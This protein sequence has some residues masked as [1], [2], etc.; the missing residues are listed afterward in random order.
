MNAAIVAAAYAAMRGGVDVPRLQ[1]GWCLRTVRRILEHAL[2][3]PEEELFRRFPAQVE[4][5]KPKPRAYWAR[6]VQASFRAAGFGVPATETLPGDVVAYWR[7]AQNDEGDYVGHIGVRLPGGFVLENIDAKYRL[8]TN[9]LADGALS[10]TPFKAWSEGRE[11]EAFR[12]Q[13][14]AL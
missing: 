5:A 4:S 8:G 11:V 6:D 3:W 1:G 2:D 13:E 9:A 12:L 14:G 7:A 10:L